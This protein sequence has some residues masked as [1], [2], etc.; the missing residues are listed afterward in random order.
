[1]NR[2]EINEIEP[3]SLEASQSVVIMTGAGIS[4][5]S[6]IPTFRDQGGLWHEHD[7]SEVATPEGFE[8][9][10]K[11]VWRFYSQRRE[12]VLQCAPNAGH[13]AIAT[14]LDGHRKNGGEGLLVT[15]NV[16]GLHERA[17]RGEEAQKGIV[18]IHG[19][20][21]R[22]KCSNA[23]CEHARAGFYDEAS[24]YDDLPTCLSCSSL[25]RPAVV[26]F[27]EM[28][29]MEDQRRALTAIDRCAF[30][31]AVGSS[32]TVY[33]V[34]AYVQDARKAGARTVLVNLDPPENLWAFHQFCHGRSA[35]ILPRLLGENTG[36]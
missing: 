21:F 17:A 18:N 4:A 26:W 24:Y 9:D 15:Q 23:G 16:D 11:L 25:L 3:L 30:F 10:P 35:E 32:G 1:M 5:E 27:G 29:V 20:L 31:V 13:H 28:L 19:S 12:Q 33:P 22:T 36:S 6:G 34:A 2:R 14:F 7:I 8:R